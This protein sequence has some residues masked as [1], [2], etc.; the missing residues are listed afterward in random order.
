MIRHTPGG[1]G[2][3]YSV[4]TEQR[5]PFAPIAGEPLR[6]GVR[7]SADTTSV[8][9]TLNTTTAAG[10]RITR[11]LELSPTANS[12]RGRTVDGGHLA[13]AQARLS[14]AQGGWSATVDGLTAGDFGVVA[15]QAKMR[16][17]AMT[18]E[19]VIAALAIE[20]QLRSPMRGRAM[21]FA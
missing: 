20:L 6:L 1:S 10:Q 8:I 18:A 2:H 7:A 13:S 14:R 12:S 9:C 21:G 17:D 3:P 16:L 15:R 11:D 5:E 19:E 4:D